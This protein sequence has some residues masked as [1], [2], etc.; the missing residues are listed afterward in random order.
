MTDTAYREIELL[1]QLASGDSNAFTVVYKQYYQ[2][3][4]YYARTFLPDKQDAEDITADTFVKLWNRRCYFQSMPAISSF[5]HITARN[6]CLDFLRHNKVKAE[7]QEE[8]VRQIELLDRSHLQQTRDEL[9][10]LIQKE[11]SKM[12]ARMKQIYQLSYDEGLS[13]AEIAQQLNI[14]VQTVSNQKT[15]VIK[16]LKKV[17][18]H[19][20]SLPLMLLLLE[21]SWHFIK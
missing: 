1:N 17:L 11:V 3:I 13:P 7:K 12:S 4:F 20:I 18:G 9:L 19:R 2:R 8:L 6:S 16:N 10:K 21:S 15:T 14:S 5:L